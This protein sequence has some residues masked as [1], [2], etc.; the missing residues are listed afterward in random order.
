MVYGLAYFPLSQE[1][2]LKQME[3]A[4]Q[5]IQPSLTQEINVFHL[6]FNYFK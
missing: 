6:I 4:G 1:K 3:F 5:T 2:Q